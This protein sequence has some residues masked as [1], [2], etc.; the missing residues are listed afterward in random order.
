LEVKE[1]L[2]EPAIEAL[3]KLAHEQW[4][5]WMLYLFEKSEGNP[6][7]S[8]TIPKWAV[9]RWMRQMQ[10]DYK[11]LPEEEKESDR[12]EALRVLEIIEKSALFS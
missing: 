2:R 8:V 3:A 11:D 10:T 1:G 9:D 7:G 4:S 6:D 5:G 12:K